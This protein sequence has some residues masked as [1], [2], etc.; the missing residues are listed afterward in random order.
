MFLA[1]NADVRMTHLAAI[2]RLI[3]EHNIDPQRILNLPKVEFMLE[4]MM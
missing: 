2:E 1:A 3:D 4:K